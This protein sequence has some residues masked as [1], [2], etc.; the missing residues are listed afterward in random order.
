MRKFICL[1]LLSS[2]LVGCGNDSTDPDTKELYQSYLVGIWKPAIFENFPSDINSEDLGCV[3]TFNQDGS[4]SVRVIESVEDNKYTFSATYDFDKWELKGYD[5]SKRD[6]V[7]E[8]EVDKGM[9]GIS[10]KVTYLFLINHI[11]TTMLYVTDLM[12]TKKESY[13]KT[14]NIEI[15]E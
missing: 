13:L 14:K 7:V 1:L 4:G 12:T 9:G 11:E 3:F 15:A 2:L 10:N 8:F 6:Y 5:G